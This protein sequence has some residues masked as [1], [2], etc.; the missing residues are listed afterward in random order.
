[1]LKKEYMSGR[2]QG[3]QLCGDLGE[4]KKDDLVTSLLSLI[5]LVDGAEVPL[6]LGG[7]SQKR[8]GG[9]EKKGKGLIQDLESP[10]R[11]DVKKEKGKRRARPQP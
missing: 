11:L 4:E 5:L 10:Y 7:L 6:G 8:A 2:M 3:R 1:M 9:Y